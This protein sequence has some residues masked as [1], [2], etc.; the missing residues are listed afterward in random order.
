MTMARGGSQCQDRGRMRGRRSLALLLLLGLAGWEPFR[1]PDPDV[2]AGNKAYAEGRY[3]DALAAYAEAAKKG[4]VPADSL[5][6]DR[7]TALLKKAEGTQG[8]GS[9]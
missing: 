4:K 6:Y 2:Q 5:A 7:G 1:S 3:D 8:E 9:R